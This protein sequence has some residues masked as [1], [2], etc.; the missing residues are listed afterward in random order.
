MKLKHGTETWN[1]HLKLKLE[2]ETRNL[3]SKLKFEIE[4]QNW[5]LNLKSKLEIDTWNST[6][7]FYLSFVFNPLI[8]GA[9]FALPW[10]L[11]A[12]FGSLGLFLRLRP[13]LKTFLEPTN[14]DYQFFCFGSTALSFCFLFSH[15]WHFLGRGQVQKHFWNL[16]M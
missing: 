9:N 8:F 10:A 5:N 7:K 13:G 4:T 16:L 12:V 6:L 3:N 1:W 11:Q 14:V 15:F 2:I